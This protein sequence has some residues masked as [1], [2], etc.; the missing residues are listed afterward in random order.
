MKK[1]GSKVVAAPLNYVKA[2]GN[3]IALLLNFTD[4]MTYAQANDAAN[5]IASSVMTSSD[6]AIV[7][8]G[9]GTQTVSTTAKTVT[10][11]LTGDPSHIVVFDTVNGDILWATNET[12]TGTVGT[13]NS[14]TIPAISYTS[15][16]PV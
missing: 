5:V 4:T 16:Q 10:P 8:N 6:F 15:N 2:N 14:V 13:Q 11:L 12:S 1:L 7:D 3:K 9:N